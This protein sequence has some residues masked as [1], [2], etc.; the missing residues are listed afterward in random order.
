ME[1]QNV[2]GADSSASG[3]GKCC[4]PIMMSIDRL[5]RK[6][7]H[8]GA[9]NV[10]GSNRPNAES[11]G[12]TLLLEAKRPDPFMFVG[13]EMNR[14]IK[15]SLLKDPFLF[16]AAVQLDVLTVTAPNSARPTFAR[17][18]F[19]TL[20]FPTRGRIWDHPQPVILEDACEAAP[21]YDRWPLQPQPWPS[22][23]AVPLAVRLLERT[24]EC[25]TPARRALERERLHRAMARTARPPPERR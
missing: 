8:G 22:S 6:A 9:A 12:K 17:L 15:L 7:R 25:R 4:A 23:A 1:V 19:L 20:R 10:L 21:P 14:F 11:R 5:S 24:S 18:R 16:A 3:G 13:P 2:R